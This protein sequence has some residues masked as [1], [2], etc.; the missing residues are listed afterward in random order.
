MATLPQASDYGARTSVRSGRLDKPS[1]GGVIEAEALS[2]AVSTFAGVLEEKKGKEDALNYALA[3]NDLISADLMERE[4]LAEDQDH[5]T[6]NERYEAGYRTA[7][8]SVT[9]RYP[10]LSSSDRAILDAEADMIGLRG[11][12]AVRGRARGLEVDQGYASFIGGM[13]TAKANL[14]QATDAETRR[15]IIEGQLE[16]I[17]AAR[18][19]GFIASEAD[20][21]V[22]RQKLTQDF[23]T[24]SIDAMSDE[25]QIRILSDSLDRRRGYGENSEDI[26]IAESNELVRQRRA[27]AGLPEFPEGAEPGDMTW[28]YQDEGPGRTSAYGQRILDSQNKSSG[29]G[30]AS[31]DDVRQGG[32]NVGDFLHADTAAKMLKAALSRNKEDRENIEAQNAMEDAR[33]RFPED[34]QAALDHV[35]RTTKGNVEER[36][37]RMARQDIQDANNAE[38]E[39]NRDVL[40]EYSEIMRSDP[41]FTYDRIPSEVL[42]DPRMR[43]VTKRNLEEFQRSLAEK[44]GGFAESTIWTTP[45]NDD[46]ERNPEDG[47]SWSEWNAMSSEEKLAQPLDTAAWMSVLEKDVWLVVKAEWEALRNPTAPTQATIMTDNEIFTE[48]MAG[49]VGGSGMLLPRTGRDE[50]QDEIW[51]RE[52]FK[53]RDRVGVESQNNYGGGAVPYQVRRDIM[54][55]MLAEKAWVRSA[56]DFDEL[57]KEHGFGPFTYWGYRDLK[58]EHPLSASTMTDE[59]RDQGFIHYRVFEN[60]MAMVNLDGVE[61][62][63]PIPWPELLRNEA[64]NRWD[65]FE[66]TQKDMENAMFAMQQNMGMP[67]VLRLLHGGGEY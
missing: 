5:A 20:A 54:L 13:E 52:L 45:V 43:E 44:R 40:T 11:G 4:K 63:R 16:A 26:T 55:N 2:N 50:E 65:G 18:D 24:A 62:D 21:E 35:R 57:E 53:F 31:A 7:R 23:A 41:S 38:V 51:N 3:K 36:A 58:Y 15:S 8:D 39:W 42:G 37:S 6:H 49:G 47:H 59:M 1:A 17:N 46:G 66:P 33:A 30:P 22:L 19:Q 48:L 60:E 32:G 29:I 12:I 25:D 61:L 28:P 56:S 34:P 64:K 27:D 9:E 10:T 14:L 67:E